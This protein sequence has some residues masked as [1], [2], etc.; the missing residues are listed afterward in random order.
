[1]NL[2][3]NPKTYVF[4]LIQ[5]GVLDRIKA[6]AQEEKG[7]TPILEFYDFIVEVVSKAPQTGRTKTFLKDFT[8]CTRGRTTAKA[9]AKRLINTIEYCTGINVFQPT[10]DPNTVDINLLTEEERAKLSEVEALKQVK[11]F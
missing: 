9:Q 2:T 3:I 7:T 8:N 10:I 5:P 4:Q 11:L 1:M 6:V